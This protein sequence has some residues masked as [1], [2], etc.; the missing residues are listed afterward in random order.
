MVDV[1]DATG[2]VLIFGGSYS[3]LEATETLFKV[4]SERGIPPE[5]IICTGD[6]T[7]YCADAEATATLI[8]ESGI[9]VVMGNT[10]ESLAGGGESCGCGFDTGSACDLLSARWMAHASETVSDVN[11][12]WMSTFPSRIDLRF[13]EIGLRFVVVHGSPKVI[14]R[15]VFSSTPDEDLLDEIDGLAADGIISG[16]CGLPY[17]RSVADVPWIN[18]GVIGMPANDGANDGWYAVLTPSAEGL[19]VAHHRLGFDHASAAAKMRQ[20]GLPEAYASS[21]ESGLWPNMDVLPPAEQTQRGMPLILDPVRLP[22]K[23]QAESKSQ[24]ESVTA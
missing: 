14:N 24:I 4:A 7:A 20:A 22:A 13:S 12:E 23:S 16:H 8:R 10:D 17:T 6:V 19:N 5:R 15:F 9:A 21:L 2:P 18:A 1:I 11:R 3:N